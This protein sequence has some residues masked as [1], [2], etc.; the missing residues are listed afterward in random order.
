MSVWGSG[1]LGLGEGDA[2]REGGAVFKLSEPLSWFALP[3]RAQPGRWGSAHAR[4]LGE[5]N[6]RLSCA[7][8]AV[9]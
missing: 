5:R 4:V 7:L 9:W 8:A 3:V 1:R 6:A 2:T